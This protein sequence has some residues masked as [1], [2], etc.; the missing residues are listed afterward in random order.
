M[1][2]NLLAFFHLLENL[3]KTKRTGWIE[4]GVK[5]PESVSD[6][7]FRLA[8]MAL[9]F[10]KKMGCDTEKL[11]AI[12]LVHDLP[13]AISGDLVL[14][15]SRFG[16][17]F[18]G[19]SEEEK[20]KREAEAEKQLFSGLDSE[21]AEHFDSLWKEFEEEKTREAKIAKQLDKFEMILQAFEYH[22]AGNFE[23]EVWPNWLAANEK[24]IREPVLK[25][26]LLELARQAH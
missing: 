22:R 4:R 24:H 19:I 16:G 25:K 1:P 5:L 17:A 8:V 26:L 3:K 18:R 10:G 12:C 9:V 20:K 14:D 11:A 23:K 2:E 13:E 21:T 6:H 15:W 7:S